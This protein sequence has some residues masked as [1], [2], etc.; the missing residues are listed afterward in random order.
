MVLTLITSR[1]GMISEQEKS[2]GNLKIIDMRIQEAM[3]VKKQIQIITLL[4]CVLAISPVG[5]WAA[6]NGAGY[7]SL[8]NGKDLSGWDGN[9]KFW[10]VKDGTI[11]GQ[12]TAENPAQGNTFLIWRLGTVEDFELHLSYRIVGGNSGIQYRSKD[13]GNWVVGGYQADFEAGKVFSGIL[14]DEKGRGIL[15]K[16]GAKNHCGCRWKSAGHGFGRR[17]RPVTGRHQE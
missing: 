9:P 5:L 6:S 8:F 3:K 11:T 17:L 13:L 4:S 2:P 16:R 7:R 15:A 10:S 14:Y 1:L 12:T